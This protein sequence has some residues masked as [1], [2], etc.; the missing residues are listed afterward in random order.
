MNEFLDLME[1]HILLLNDIIDTANRKF[2]AIAAND[3]NALNKCISEDEANSLRFKGFDKKREEMANKFGVK[4][5]FEYVQTLEGEE[6][7]YGERIA[8]LLRDRAD[9]L[10]AVNSTNE[11]CIKLNIM[12]LEGVLDMLGSKK[13]TVYMKDGTPQSGT[14]PKTKFKTQKI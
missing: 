13:Q 14:A 8:E 7:S 12:Q 6:K 9:V 2:D 4:T 5:F 3:L 10:K 1:K 11:R